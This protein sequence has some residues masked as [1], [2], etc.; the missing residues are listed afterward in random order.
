MLTRLHESN[1]RVTPLSKHRSPQSLVLGHRGNRRPMRK[2]N[3][4][5]LVTAIALALSG[6]AYSAHANFARDTS[7]KRVA[8]DVLVAPS[9]APKEKSHWP[10]PTWTEWT[11]RQPSTTSPTTSD[12]T[13]AS[14]TT[15]GPS[16]SSPTTT[17]PSTTSQTTSSPSTSPPSTGTGSARWP[18]QVPGKFYLGMSCGELCSQKEQALNTDY[19]VHRQFK[20]WG[21]W[22]GVAKAIQGDQRAGRLPWV[23]IKPPGSGPSGWQAIANGQYDSDIKALAT[24]LKANDSK[25]VLITFH[26]EPSND[27]SE[28]QGKVWAAA[29]CRFHDVLNNAGAL[30][31]VADP[32]ILGDWLFNPTNRTQD[33]VNWLTPG[34]MQRMPF[35]GVDMYENTS[36]DTFADRIPGIINWMAQ[37]GYPNKMIGIGETGATDGYKAATGLTAAQWM[38]ESLSWVAA[39]TDKVGVVSYFNST[40]NS[41]SGVYWP[42][43]ESLAK[44]TA[45]RAWLADTK[46]VG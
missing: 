35:L 13:T 3:K 34:V 28:S 1:R 22:S 18:G 46:T 27:G 4:T 31:N 8:T 42:L 9:F 45:Y 17:P 44:M 37:H 10:E 30:Q 36:G 41:R 32:P 24:V 26:H 12:P 25:P 2:R 39:N 5:V 15:S 16:T 40:N 20:S 21:N 11:T 43:D 7:H 6:A 33:P 29:Y 19:G 23:S 38:N 14:P